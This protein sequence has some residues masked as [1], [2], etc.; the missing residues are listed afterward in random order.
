MRSLP[1][2]R[3]PCFSSPACSSLL[4]RGSDRAVVRRPGGEPGLGVRL[5]RAPRPRALSLVVLSLPPAARSKQA[6]LPS[7]TR[8]LV[9]G[10]CGLGLLS[11]PLRTCP[12]LSTGAASHPCGDQVT[13]SRCRRPVWLPSLLPRPRGAPAV[14]TGL[15]PPLYNSVSGEGL[16]DHS[17]HT[18]SLSVG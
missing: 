1:G 7:V 13:R 8:V 11:W 14:A 12:A 5:G 16:T 10:G 9:P 6:F 15:G 17:W 18:G 2:A 3:G 4:C